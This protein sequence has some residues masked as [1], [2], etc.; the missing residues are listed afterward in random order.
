ME[1]EREGEGGARRVG[2]GA[3]CPAFPQ[4]VGARVVPLLRKGNLTE[5]CLRVTPVW[6]EGGA[7]Q[8]PC[9]ADRPT[10]RMQNM[11]LSTPAYGGGLVVCCG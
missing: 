7:E 1:R 5:I 3:V 8:T 10:G 6:P 11:F 2:R 4:R 9:C